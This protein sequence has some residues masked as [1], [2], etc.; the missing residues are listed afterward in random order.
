MAGTDFLITS[1]NPDG[2]WGYKRGGTSFVEPTASAIIAL[3]ETRNSSSPT[4]ARGLAFLRQL[5]HPDGGW[6]IAAIDQES[7]WMTAWAAWALAPDDP[8]RAARAADWLITVDVLRTTDPAEIEGIRRVLK[9]DASLRGWPWQMRDA[10]WTFPT[11]IA[12]LALDAQN[13]DSDPRLAEGVRF[14]LDRAIPSG[15]WNI[16]NPSMLGAELPATIINTGLVVGVLNALAVS[17][18]AV[19]RGYEWLASRLQEARTAPELAWGIWG[20]R[21]HPELSGD[22]PARLNALIRADGSWDGNPFI[23]AIAVL[24]LI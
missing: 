18:P 19:T 7:G 3:R 11:G 23:S 17:D 22:A 8:T 12:L 10:S 2:G 13:R 4:Y 16:G 1:Q 6:G 14:L 20:L 5:Q 24:A 21:G 15:G 9:I